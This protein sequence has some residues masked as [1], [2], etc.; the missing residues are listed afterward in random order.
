MQLLQNIAFFSRKWA[1]FKTARA[2]QVGP[3][4][5]GGLPKGLLS[6]LENW[7]AVT[8]ARMPDPGFMPDWTG[9]TW[10]LPQCQ[11][12][13]IAST[14]VISSVAC[15]QP[16][17][18]N[19]SCPCALP[20]YLFCFRQSIKERNS[21]HNCL[22][23]CFPVTQHLWQ[24]CFRD[25]RFWC[26][27]MA[28]LECESWVRTEEGQRW[29]VSAEEK[30]EEL[31][32]WKATNFE[33][34]KRVNLLMVPNP[35]CFGNIYVITCSKDFGSISLNIEFVWYVS[36]IKVLYAGIHLSQSAVIQE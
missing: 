11:W 12:L 16:K 8:Q 35:Q 33:F 25:C 21:A 6:K 13:Q 9:V 23:I 4:C 34:Q 10:A 28:L 27:L 18:V 14:E 19:S 24:V 22:C 32:K 15:A 20:V 31:V 26:R 1:D 7:A 30:K 5:T 3:H 2:L 36:S 29:P 17:F